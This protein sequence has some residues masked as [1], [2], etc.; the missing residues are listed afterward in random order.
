MQKHKKKIQL[1]PTGAETSRF[2]HGAHAAIVTVA[3]VRGAGRDG[4]L[5]EWT[6]SFSCLAWFWTAWDKWPRGPVH[7]AVLKTH[8]LSLE[9]WGERARRVHGQKHVH[10]TGGGLEKNPKMTACVS[11]YSKNIYNL[12]V[13]QTEDSAEMI[14]FLKKA[15]NMSLKWLNLIFVT[16]WWE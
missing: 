14:T 13:L 4:V 7:W 11:C 10:V 6:N 9:D 16:F 5:C 8:H 2:V 3:R 15:W 1:N 12:F